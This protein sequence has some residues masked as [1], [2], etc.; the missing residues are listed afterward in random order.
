MK[1]PLK[2]FQEAYGGV[3]HLIAQSEHLLLPELENIKQIKNIAGVIIQKGI[4]GAGERGARRK[5]LKLMRKTEWLERH[6]R[7]KLDA[8][9]ASYGELVSALGSTFKIISLS[10]VTFKI[11]T[12]HNFLL[13]AVSRRDGVLSSAVRENNWEQMVSSAEQALGNGGVPLL[14]IIS[15]L[16]EFL[17][18]NNR[19]ME[20]E[21]VRQNSIE[22]N[23]G[24]VSIPF[25]GIPAEPIFIMDADFAASVEKYRV[26]QG[27][28]LYGLNIPRGKILIPDKV[29]R[30][31]SHHPSWAGKRLVSKGLINY[32]LGTGKA[33]KVTVA[34]SVEEKE[35]ML[36]LWIQTAKGS[37]LA[38]SEDHRERFSTSG[39]MEILV[40]ASRNAR[41]RPVIILSNDNDII[42]VAR[43]IPGAIAVYSYERGVLV[44]RH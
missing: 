31:M 1:N 20:I 37:R 22:L 10:E 8:F 43:Y 42:G 41:K 16:K 23:L 38:Y 12:Y 4:S 18:N 32:L 29:Y 25:R 14:A 30:E 24:T 36:R 33:E 19:G 27:K 34:P 2:E 17:H 5:C 40:H 15:Q 3:K 44:S 9:L 28:F 11:N 7:Q 6:L 39:D 26:S 35:Q 13:R 21:V